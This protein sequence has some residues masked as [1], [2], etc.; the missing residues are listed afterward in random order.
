MTEQLEY[1]TNSCAKIKD[2][3]IARC[4]YYGF[5]LFLIF[6]MAFVYF[7]Y[8]I[9]SLDQI[10]PW[11]LYS[12]SVTYE[13]IALNLT[14]ISV[15]NLLTVNG[16]L[17]GP[18]LLYKCVGYNRDIIVL[19]NICCFMAT[20]YMLRPIFRYTLLSVAFLLLINPLIF[21][22][23]LTLNKE[24]PSLLIIALVIHARI[25]SKKRYF[26]IALLFSIF[27]RYQLTLFLAMYFLSFSRLNFFRKSKLVTVIILVLTASVLYAILSKNLFSS[28]AMIGTEKTEG[29]TGLMNKL[30]EIQRRGGYFLIVF[31]KVFFIMT[32][33]IT[34]ISKF[35]Q[36]DDF[37]NF[38]II[39][40]H[41]L[42]C[43]CMLISIGV[44]IFMRKLSTRNEI[45]YLMILYAVFFGVSPIFAPRY[46]LI[47]YFLGILL[48]T[49]R[50]LPVFYFA[51]L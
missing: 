51:K 40:S 39:L 49:A 13:K 48:L 44:K 35:G 36:V 3:S 28:I 41:S 5:V 45:I 20:L 19:I 1:V 34:K 16:N 14:E 26:I 25:N 38:T 32:L 24:I 7:F 33:L 30:N 31:M 10:I 6:F 43:F 17:I 12:D 37:W 4:T 18:I 42:A 27:V 46:F 11:Q 8:V 21:L 2:D 9:P 22:S 15:S 50:R 23:I 47:E 29:G